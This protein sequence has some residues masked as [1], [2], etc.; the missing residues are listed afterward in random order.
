MYNR[1]CRVS[2]LFIERGRYT[3]NSKYFLFFPF[4]YKICKFASFKNG[5]KHGHKN[6]SRIVDDTYYT[7]GRLKYY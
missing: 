4:Y 2:V 3:E 5:L 1:L 7:G 6:S